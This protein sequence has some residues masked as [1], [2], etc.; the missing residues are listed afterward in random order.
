MCKSFIREPPLWEKMRREPEKAEPAADWD[1]NAKEGRRLGG[2]IPDHRAT[3]G[4]PASLGGVLKPRLVV[5][6]VHVSWKWALVPC[7]SWSLVG[8]SPREAWLGPKLSH[9]FYRWVSEQSSRGPL[10]ND[11]PIDRG[12][13]LLTATDYYSSFF[14]SF[15]WF[16]RVG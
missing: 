16:L 9:G 6:R 5:G 7:Q 8:N 14:L 12:L 2:S 10:V 11:T 15:G 1:E 3:W 4:C 13:S